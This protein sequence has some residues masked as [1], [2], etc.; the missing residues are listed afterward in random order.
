MGVIGIY[1]CEA[2]PVTIKARFFT[3]EYATCHGEAESED[4]RNAEETGKTGEGML[5]VN[6]MLFTTELTENTEE[7]E[8]KTGRKRACHRELT[9][10]EAISVKT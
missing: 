2:T 3:A 1:P 5:P 9:P 8:S 4:G 10:C 6:A 7:D